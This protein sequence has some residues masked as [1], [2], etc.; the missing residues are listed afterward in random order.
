MANQL[1]KIILISKS[2]SWDHPKRGE[3]A[4]GILTIANK[5]LD[6]RRNG[7]LFNLI[8]AGEPKRIIL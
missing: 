4:R 1:L 3:I 6:N 8:A 2:T 7:Q 5:K